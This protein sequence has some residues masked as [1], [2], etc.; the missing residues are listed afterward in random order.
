MP[1]RADH[2]Q[3]TGLANAA[4]LLLHHGVVFTLHPGDR[5]AQR[6]NLGI[7]SG[8]F[9]RSGGDALLQLNHREGTVAPGLDQITR[10]LAEG[11][12]SVISEGA[13]VEALTAA[14][15]RRRRSISEPARSTAL[16]RDGRLVIFLRFHK[17]AQQHLPQLQAGHVV[18]VAAKNDV[19]ATAR[20]VGGDGHGASSTRLGDDLRFALHVLRLGVEQVVGDLLLRQQRTQQF[21]FLHRGGAHQHRPAVFVDL[22]CFVGHSAPLGSLGFVHLIGP[23]L[24][25]PHPI[26]GDDCGFEFV[27]LLKFHLLGLGGAGHAGQAGI[28]QKKVL[29]RDRSECLRFR[30]DLQGLLGLNSLMLAVT[31]TTARHHPTGELIHDHRLAISH[32]VIHVLDEQLLGLKGVG[33]V[34]SPGVLRVKQVRHPQASA[35]LW[36][37]LHQ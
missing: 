6:L 34:V 2:M 12:I 8:S 30:L 1:F 24:T 36:Q 35:R 11:L 17:T 22:S 27:S 5:L 23:V 7:L 19:G 37:S 32:D 14:G 3:A 28:E 26:G 16:Q 13:G 10:Q 20:H 4:F 15:Q 21:A 25:C 33:D 9:L 29:I 18:A 31:P